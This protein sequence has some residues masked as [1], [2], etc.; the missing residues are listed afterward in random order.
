MFCWL[1][2]LIISDAVDAEKRLSARTQRHIRHCANCRGFHQMCLSLGKGLER[3]AASLEDESAVKSVRRF[4]QAV[5]EREIETYRLSV[6][7]RLLAVAASVVVAA[8]L[9]AAFFTLRSS[10]P[11]TPEPVRMA[12][13]YGLMDGG[14]P[15]V[16]A[17]LA[18]KPLADEI[19]NLAANTEC[20]V[21]FL[22][23][24][25]AVNPSNAPRLVPN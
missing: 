17:G 20:A 21:R 24:C 2:K 13:L 16:W 14:H 12:G 8:L 10:E 6:N 15:A 4:L 11:P 1:Y 23:A 22:V 5:P 3:E 18:E 19:N 9:A 25:V 7:R